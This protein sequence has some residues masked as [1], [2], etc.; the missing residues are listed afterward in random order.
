MGP[1]FGIAKLVQI[2][3]ITIVYYILMGLCSPTNITGGA[4][5]SRWRFMVFPGFFSWENHLDLWCVGGGLP[6]DTHGPPESIFG[7]PLC[8][9][10]MT[11]YDSAASPPLPSVLLPWL[12]QS[13]WH[14]AVNF[15][16]KGGP[17]WGPHRKSWKPMRKTHL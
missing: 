17:T 16:V 3:I 14:P 2:T 13:L 4:P 1:Q 8:G 12:L 5:C 6:L 9:R 15:S 11:W 10:L 7:V